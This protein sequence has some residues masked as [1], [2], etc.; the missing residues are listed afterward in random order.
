MAAGRRRGGDARTHLAHG[1]RARVSGPPPIENLPALLLR[2]RWEG[3]G[4]GVLAGYRGGL[5]TEGELAIEIGTPAY[6]LNSPEVASAVCARSGTTASLLLPRSLVPSVRTD[7]ITDGSG[8]GIYCQGPPASPT[9]GSPPPFGPAG[10]PRGTARRR[11]KSLRRRVAWL[12]L[13]SQLPCS[14]SST[15]GPSTVDPMDSVRTWRRNAAAVD[16]CG[17]IAVL[18]TAKVM[19]INGGLMDGLI[20]SLS[21]PAGR[22]PACLPLRSIDRPVCLRVARA[23][24]PWTVLWQVLAVASLGGWCMAGW[25]VGAAVAAAGRADFTRERKRRK[26]TVALRVRCA[27]LRRLRLGAPG[28]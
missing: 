23:M 10:Q 5:E 11:E 25:H 6:Q 12:S 9:P 22:K 26:E 18:C 8:S 20:S 15:G 14:S 19:M 24:P 21:S 2:L 1:R 17:R 13:G 16:G 28:S 27:A 3:E 4:V 7:Q